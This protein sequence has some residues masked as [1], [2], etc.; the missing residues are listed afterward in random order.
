MYVYNKPFLS[1]EDQLNLL[2]QKGM[3]ISDIETAKHHLKH[4][5][6]YRLSGYFYLMKTDITSSNIFKKNSLFSDVINLY[7]FD[8][9]LRSIMIDILKRIEISLRSN[10]SQILGK[11][12]P[13]A[14]INEK[15]YTKK[16]I[17]QKKYETLITS[18]QKKYEKS[19]DDCIKSFKSKYSNPLPVWISSE[20]WD[21][22]ILT[23]II[24]GMKFEYRK[25]LANLYRISNPL[26]IS[27]WIYS[28]NHVRNIC[29][30]HGRLWN[31]NLLIEPKY[32]NDFNLPILNHLTSSKKSSIYAIAAIAKYFENFIDPYSSW[33]ND[34]IKIIKNFPT[35]EHFQLS[36]FP[37]DWQ[38]LDLWK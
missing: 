6:Y 22:G 19:Q 27:S 9:K 16:F 10:I 11:I 12:S 23:H 25:Q 17:N 18:I 24:G 33:K 5:S 32:P 29:A 14:Y 3:I 34:F 31:R 26:L 28:L 20:I 30:H 21:F 15:S 13:H 8:D 1:I 4:I 7:N 2:I 38:Q 36:N 37:K 35:T